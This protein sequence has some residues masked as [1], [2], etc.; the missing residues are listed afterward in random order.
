MHML[1]TSCVFVTASQWPDVWTEAVKRLG[2]DAAEFVANHLGGLLHDVEVADKISPVSYNEELILFVAISV[3]IIRNI[4]R[5]Y[6]L[7]LTADRVE[8]T[9]DV[10]KNMPR[11]RY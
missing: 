1:F 11:S 8:C 7:L 2:V 6:T 10:H 3:F 5:C 9:C 4:G